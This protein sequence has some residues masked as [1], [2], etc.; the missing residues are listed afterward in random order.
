[1][2]K[3][4]FGFLRFAQD[5]EGNINFDNINTLVDKYMELGGRYF[6]TAWTYLDGKK[7]GSYPPMHSAALSAQQL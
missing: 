7:R 4:G 3:M 5:A 6:D 2:N 1:M